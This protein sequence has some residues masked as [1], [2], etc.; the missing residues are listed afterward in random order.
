MNFK[1][2]GIKS[3]EESSVQYNPYFNTRTS[4]EIFKKC[5]DKNETDFRIESTTDSWGR[6][7]YKTIGTTNFTDMMNLHS[8]YGV[9]SILD[10][11]FRNFKMSELSSDCKKDG[12]ANLNHKNF[13]ETELSISFPSFYNCDMS[14]APVVIHS[15]R[16]LTFE[17][18]MMQNTMFKNTNLPRRTRFMNCYMEDSTFEDCTTGQGPDPIYFINCV[19]DGTKMDFNRKET[20]FNNSIPT[21]FFTNNLM[22]YMDWSKFNVSRSTIV[23]KSCD[24]TGINFDGCHLNDVKS[25]DP[26]L[27]SRIL[28]GGGTI[29]R[30][31]TF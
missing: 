10:G 23:L 17:N 20:I 19:M 26:E 2:V 13:K 27:R 14:N 8:K 5:V 15:S 1:K 31:K 29:N 7:V 24:T 18:C 22:R 11:T 6:Q 28:I 3:G 9:Q 12:S 4:F 30:N 25:D 16:D 21:I